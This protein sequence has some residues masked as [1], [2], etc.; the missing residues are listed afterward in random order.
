MQLLC[1]TVW[2]FLKE[3]KT[4]VQYDWEKK[5]QTISATD[6]CTPVFIAALF[7]IAKT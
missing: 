7:A 2:K 3:M 4:E 1:N 5:P 6:T